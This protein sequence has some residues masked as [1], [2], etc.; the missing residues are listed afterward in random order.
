M[1]S[2]GLIQQVKRFQQEPLGTVLEDATPGSLSLNSKYTSYIILNATGGLYTFKLNTETNKLIITCIPNKTECET[3]VHISGDIN[4]V[5]TE[6][7][8]NPQKV[9]GTIRLEEGCY[10]FKVYS[11]GVMHTVGKIIKSWGGSCTLKCKYSKPITLNATSG[12]YE[13]IFEKVMGTLEIKRH[14]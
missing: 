5:L 4:L 12:T 10:T 6:T 3:D 7:S 1:E 8:Y 11:Y 9:S 2:R 14:Y 13:F